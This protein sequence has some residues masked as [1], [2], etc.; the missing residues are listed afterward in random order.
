MTRL[1]RR[2]KVMIVSIAQLRQEIKWQIRASQRFTKPIVCNPQPWESISHSLTS[3]CSAVNVR[4]QDKR[5]PQKSVRLRKRFRTPGEASQ[6][7]SRVLRLNLQKSGPTQAKTTWPPSDNQHFILAKRSGMILR[8]VMRITVSSARCRAA[9][10]VDTAPTTAEE[11]IGVG[12]LKVASPST[13]AMSQSTSASMIVFLQNLESTDVLSRSESTMIMSKEES[14]TR[15]W[16]L[17]KHSSRSANAI[18]RSMYWL[19]LSHSKTVA[20]FSRRY[21]SFSRVVSSVCAPSS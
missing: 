8:V 20:I 17:Y 12:S 2:T 3:P 15:K 14:K 9:T 13:P 16:T 18:V 11:A 10:T 19:L 7:L 1:V 21:P 4:C 6:T 5:F